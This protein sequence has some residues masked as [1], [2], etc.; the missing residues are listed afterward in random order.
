VRYRPFGLNGQAMSVLTLALD[1]PGLKAAAVTELVFS[2]LECGINSFELQAGDMEAARGLRDGLAAVERSIA[3]VGLRLSAAADPRFVSRDGAIAAIE[4]ALDSGRFGRLDYVLVEGRTPNDLSPLLADTLAGASAAGRIRVAGLGGKRAFLD[5]HLNDPEFELIEA[6]F[7]LRSDWDD[8]N[9][10]KRA[11]A[12]GMTVI[13]CDYY[14]APQVARRDA[15]AEPRHGLLRFGLGGKERGLEQSSAYAFLSL[16]Q[17]WT[18]EEICLAY[19]LTEPGLSSIH[20]SAAGVRNLP[21]LAAAPDREM[22]TGVPAQIE[23][24]RIQAS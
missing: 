3:V 14:P 16:Y 15:G 19:A 9:R 22:P 6:P 1:R 10:V 13:G 12:R 24:A 4:G 5:A 20:I 8:R 18:A 21:A 23:M 11:A 17:G 2:A 7:N